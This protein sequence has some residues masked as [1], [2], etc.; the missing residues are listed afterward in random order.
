VADRRL[1]VVFFPRYTTLVGSGSFPTMPLDVTEFE[2]LDGLLWRSL[3]LGATPSIHLGFEGSDDGT[4]WH[5]LA[6]GPVDPG[7]WTETLVPV[8]LKRR[9]LRAKAILVGADTAASLYMVG[10]LERRKQ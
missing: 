1:P 6:P 8:Q 5:S 9:Y 10:Y 2:E 3:L 4:V 7:A